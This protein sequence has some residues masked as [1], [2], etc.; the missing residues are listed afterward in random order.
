MHTYRYFVRIALLISAFGVL[1]W[2]QAV[3]TSQIQGIV[4]DASGLVVPG[5]AIRATQTDTG[6]VR[7]VTSEADGRYVLPSLPVGPYTLEV[8]KQGFATYLQTG[9]VLQVTPAF[10]Y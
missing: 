10:R 1:A 2:S 9:I 6:A 7:N 3:S 8:S 4:Q 5:A